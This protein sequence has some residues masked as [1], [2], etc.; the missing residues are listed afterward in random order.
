M[1]SAD[2]I[3]AVLLTGFDSIP[4]CSHRDVGVSMGQNRVSAHDLAAVVLAGA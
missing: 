1:I 2:A 4:D 3:P